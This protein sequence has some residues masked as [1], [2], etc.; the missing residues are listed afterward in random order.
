VELFIPVFIVIV[1]ALVGLLV[2]RSYDKKLITRVIKDKEEY[3]KLFEV[4]S[5]ENKDQQ[6]KIQAFLEAISQKDIWIERGMQ[7][8]ENSNKLLKE[9]QTIL[10]LRASEILSLQEALRFQEEQ[11]DK[12]LGQKKSSEVRTGKI[13]EQLSPFLNDYPLAPETAKFIGDPI[14]FVHFDEDKITFVE[15]KSGKSQ[16][17]RKQKDIKELVEQGKVAFLIYRVEGK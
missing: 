3:Q 11:Y 1:I 17:S 4:S 16:L 5:L 6:T 8:V 10:D 9:T 7:A 12:L 14:D 13:T 2:Q 15:V